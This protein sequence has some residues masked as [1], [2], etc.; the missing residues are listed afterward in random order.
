MEIRV[1][2]ITRILNAYVFLFKSVLKRDLAY[3]SGH[4]YFGWKVPLVL[5]LL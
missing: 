1:I 5:G 4:K 3:G 2:N